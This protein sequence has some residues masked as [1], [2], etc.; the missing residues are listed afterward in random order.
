MGKVLA[1]GFDVPFAEAIEAAKARGVVLPDVYYGQL[2][3]GARAKAFSIAGIT[4]YDQLKAVKAA[5]DAAMQNGQS[6]AQWKKAILETGVDLPKH[7]LD[8]IFRTNLQG[9]YMAGRWEQFRR[10][11]DGRPYLMYDA[12]NDSRVRPSHLAMDNVIRHVDDPFWKT[13]SPPNGFRCRCSIISMTEAQ[14][15]ARSRDG[16]GL[17]NPARTQDGHAAT[18][19]KGWEFTP[20]NRL[21]GVKKALQ[22]KTTEPGKLAEALKAKVSSELPKNENRLYWTIGTKQFMWHQKSFRDSPAWIKGSIEKHDDKF[23]HLFNDATK[24]ASHKDASINMSAYKFSEYSGQLV[25]RHE[26]GHFLDNQIGRER[27]TGYR[28]HEADFQGTMKAETTDILKASGFGRRTDAYI[29]SN[30][31]R[32]RV[33]DRIRE[34]VSV[35]SAADRR[36]YIDNE[37]ASLG[38]GSGEVIAFFERET[39]HKMDGLDRDL[40]AAKLIQAIKTRDAASFSEAILINKHR[41]DVK[42]V[43]DSLFG[44]FSDLVG[45][46]SLNKLMGHGAHGMG[47]HPTA[48][49]KRKGS[50]HRQGSEV[51]ANLTSILGS[52]DGFWP[53]V[54]QAFYPKLSQLFKEI[55]S[56]ET[57]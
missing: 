9:D 15:Q 20:E 48:Y 47:G 5:L 36:A 51:F 45:S 1:V 30:L 7:R 25:W 52:P 34:I 23:L 54:A 24:G 35:M 31:N 12:I 16:K 40:R 56:N 3:A 53:K 14:A 11:A 38:I 46:A 49:Y 4:S 27:K 22:E 39:A 6:F 19:D 2:Q 18:P 29:D 42:L 37:A 32:L 50:E 33:Y 43:Y 28:S 17:E 44:L 41:D 21:S 13:H 10:N 55:L 8:N 57:K 26:Y